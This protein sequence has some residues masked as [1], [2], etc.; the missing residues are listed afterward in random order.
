MPYDTEPLQEWEQ[1]LLYTAA[2]TTER[3]DMPNLLRLTEA[4]ERAGVGGVISF[5]RGSSAGSDMLHPVIEM[6]NGD[7][8][9]ENFGHRAPLSSY[10]Q[11]ERWT[12]VSQSPTAAERFPMPNLTDLTDIRSAI[13]AAG[14]VGGIIEHRGGDRYV[15]LGDETLSV[16]RSTYDPLGYIYA[17]RSLSNVG[18][19][20]VPVE[21][22]GPEETYTPVTRSEAIERA[23][24]NGV[25]TRRGIRY[26]VTNEDGQDLLQQ[27]TRY[28]E[29]SSPPERPSRLQQDSWFVSGETLA[30]H[31][32]SRSYIHSCQD[33]GG[34]INVYEDSYDHCDECENYT[35]GSCDFC[36][37]EPYVDPYYRDGDEYGIH[38]WN[39]RPEYVPKG[40]GV[41]MGVELEVGGSRRSISGVVR[42]IDESQ[43]HL[44]MKDDGSISGVEI[45]THP[46]TLDYAAEFP[47]TPLLENLVES[48]SNID[49]GYGLHIH[50]DRDAFKMRSG[51]RSVAH[52][53]SWL[54]FMYRNT[55]KLELLARRRESRW[56]SF[57]KPSKGVL[58]EK[59][60]ADRGYSDDRYLAVNTNN[61]PTY[62]LRFFKSTLDPQEFYGA[63]EFADASVEY[64]RQLK[65]P[66]ILQGGGMQWNHFSA[67]VGKHSDRY[68]NLVAVMADMDRRGARGRRMSDY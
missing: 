18:W 48:G 22:R 30:D 17:V 9:L 42:G 28:N 8:G 55:E 56:A 66:D 44:Y 2:P 14:D 63:V 58:K 68:S 6:P 32:I 45:V 34:D 15:Y 33:C 16:V 52:Q 49:N 25:I 23:G 13:A 39:Y 27:L 43:D 64:T 46:M 59:A 41:L 57:R 11:N 40:S 20:A 5:G 60:Q 19:R 4:V 29:A 1:E 35:C 24:I 38:S 47:F 54:M 36:D 50:V 31:Q 26:R 53:M 65:T 21:E 62:E 67:W 3:T 12:V 7:I 51:K 10:V 37:C 61:R